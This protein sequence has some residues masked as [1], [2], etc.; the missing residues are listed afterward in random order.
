M[1]STILSGFQL[2]EI[3]FLPPVTWVRPITH[4]ARIRPP[5]SCKSPEPI[6]RA[7]C[8]WVQSSSSS[9]RL[10]DKGQTRSRAGLGYF[11]HRNKNE[12]GVAV[13]R[14]K[15]GSQK[16]LTPPARAAVSPPPPAHAPGLRSDHP[17][18]Q[19]PP[20]AAPSARLRP[21]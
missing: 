11:L 20:T 17:H 7:S 19:S 18:S 5:D 12:P 15:A 16:P 8:S 13:V 2:P 21:S 10:Q 3:R 4:S 9:C 14:L 6:I 1:S